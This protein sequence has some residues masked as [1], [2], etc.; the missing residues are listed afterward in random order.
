MI[1]NMKNEL[2][3]RIE[4]AIEEKAMK[5]EFMGNELINITLTLTD[6]ELD[7]FKKMDLDEDHYTFEIE[8]NEVNIGYMEKVV[9]KG[10]IKNE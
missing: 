5:Y 4:D 7:T 3:E 6:E 2:T 1:N 10:D 9:N 8:G